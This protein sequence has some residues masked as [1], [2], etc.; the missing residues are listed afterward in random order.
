MPVVADVHS[1]A[2]VARFKYGIAGIPRREI[3]LLPESRMAMRDVVLAVLA[4]IL[5]V[6]IDHGS[7]VE[8]NARHLHLIHRHDQRHAVFLRKLPHVRDGWPA[9]HGLGKVVPLGLLLGAE[10]W[11]VEQLLEPE[12]LH[13][14]SS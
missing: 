6:G 14:A 12:D 4:E 5:S 8:V 3:K 11:P 10:V 1:D 7:S 2:A 9:G 13:F